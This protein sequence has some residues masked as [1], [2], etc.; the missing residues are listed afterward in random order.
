MNPEM[1]TGVPE[2]RCAELAGR[3]D[4][5]IGGELLGRLAVHS[6]VDHD[7]L[8]RWADSA[9]TFGRE[10]AATANGNPDLDVTERTGGVEPGRRILLAEYRSRPAGVVVYTD[11]VERAESLI[12]EVGW[13]EW[14][15]AG[16]VRAAAVAHETAHQLLHGPA[17]TRLR[18]RVGKVALRLGSWTVHAHVVGAP[19]LAAHGFAAAAAGLARTPVLLTAALGELAAALRH[20]AERDV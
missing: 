13:R 9:L 15:P 14:Y 2:R 1:I 18:R 19:E 7:T 3:S 4:A 5:D 11:A 8:A 6:A 10:L 12:D 17:A 16:S 20:P